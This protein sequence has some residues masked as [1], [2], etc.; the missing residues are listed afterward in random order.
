M[1]IC[2]KLLI[3]CSLI[4]FSNYAVS[5][6][7]LWGLTSTGGAN[8]EGT[9][10]YY[11]L[12]SNSWVTEHNFSSAGGANP[13]GSLALF[14]GKLYGMTTKGGANNKGVIFEY[15]PQTKV[16]TKKVDFTGDNGSTPSGSLTLLNNKF[17]GMTYEGGSKGYG[18][19]FEWDPVTNVIAKKINWDARY[20]Y[21]AGPRGSLLLDN[22]FLYGMTSS[23]AGYDDAFWRGV[24]FKWN[25]ATGTVNSAYL[26]GSGGRSPEGSLTRFGSRFYGLTKLGGDYDG[27]SLIEWGASSP[28]T[29]KVSFNQGFPT[30]SLIA[31]N[32]KLYGL[33]AGSGSSFGY[34]FSWDPSSNSLQ[35]L[36]N[37]DGNN[38]SRP[39]G[40]LSYSNGKLYGLTYEGGA[41]NLGTLFEFDLTTKVLQKKVDFSN[42]TG[43]NPY[44]TQLLEVGPAPEPISQTINFEALSSKTFGDAE[45]SLTAIASSGLEVAYTSS[46]PTVATISGEKVTMLKAGTVV[47]TASQPGNS[48]YRAATSVQQV[49]TISKFTPSL[50]WNNPADIIYGTP[51]TL[52]QLSC[53]ASSSGTLVYTPPLGTVLNVGNNQPLSVTF[54]PSN[55]ASVNSVSL[56]VFINVLNPPPNDESLVQ[57]KLWGVTSTGGINDG[58]TIGYFGVTSGTWTTVYNFE[59]TTG[60][61]PKGSLSLFNGKLYGM[62]SAGGSNNKGVIFEYDPITKTYTKKIDFIGTNGGN[63]TGSL[64]LLNNKFYGMTYSGGSSPYGTLFEWNPSTNEYMVKVNFNGS[65]GAW[66]YGSLLVDNGLLY[67]LTSGGVD[68]DQAFWYGIAFSFDPNSNVLKKINPFNIDNG[69]GVGIAK[70]PTCSLVKFG[71]KFYGVSKFGGSLDFGTIFEWNGTSEISK[72]TP[73]ISFSSSNPYPSGSLALAGDRLYGTTEGPNGSIFEYDPTN[74]TINSGGSFDGVNGKTPTGTFTFSNGKLYG[75]TSSGGTSNLGTLVEYNPTTKI[76]TKKVDFNYSTGGNPVYT[77]LLEIAAA[78]INQIIQFEPIANKIFGTGPFTLSASASSGLN[79][80]FSSSDPTIASISGNTVTI[81]KAGI[82]TITASQSGNSSYNAAANVSQVL[83]IEKNTPTISWENP[84]DINVGTPLSAAQLNATTTVAGSFAYS[85]AIG[86]VLPAGNN[87]PLSVTFTPTNS[88]NYNTVVKQAFVNV[89]NFNPPSDSQIYGFTNSGGASNNGTIFKISPNGD[90]EQVLFNFNISTGSPV[91]KPILASNGKYYGLTR[92]GGASDFGILFEYD[93]TSGIFKKIADMNSV[94]GKNPNGTLIQSSLNGKIYGTCQ[95]GGISGLGMGI[96][97]EFDPATSQV[98]KKISFNATSYYAARNPSGSLLETSTGKIIGVGR[99][100]LFEYDIVGATYKTLLTMGNDLID[101]GAPGPPKDPNPSIILGSDGFIYGSTTTGGAGETSELQHGTLFKIALNGT[102]NFFFS[103]T[104]SVLSGKPN[105]GVT[106]FNGKL[107]GTTGGGGTDNC[108]ELFEFDLS[109]NTMTK[110]AD[111][112]SA[113]TGANPSS[114]LT[115]VDGKL[116][117]MTK[118]GGANGNGTIFEFDPTSGTL[119][120]TFDFNGSNGQP[121]DNNHLFYQPSSKTSQSI[122]FAAIEEKNYGDAPFMLSA[123]A[124]SGLSVSFSSSDPSV[125]LISGNEVTILKA[126]TTT[127]TATQNGNDIYSPSPIV[128]QTLIVNKLIPVITWANPSDIVYGIV[129]N[130]VQ[131]NAVSTVSGTFVYSPSSG[132]QL[133]AGVNQTLSVTF[134]PTD[135]VNYTNVTKQVALNVTKAVPAITWANP[136]DIIYGTTLSVAQLNASSLISGSFVYS[137]SSGTKP[138]AGANQTLSVTFTPTDA[139]NY[140]NVTKQVALNV[141]KAIP[142]ITWANPSDIVYGTTLSVAQL[143]ATSS[144]SG[145]FV[146]SPSSGTKPN[147]GTNQ[148]LSVTFTPTDAVNYTNVTKQVALN[149]TKALPAITWSNPSAIVYGTTLSVAQLNASSSIPGT[150]VYSPSSGTKPNAGA[151]QALSVTFTPTDAVNYTNVTKQ[152]ALNVTKAVPAITWLNPSAIVYG[153]TLSGAQLNASSSIAGTFVYSPS[154]GTKLNAG[155]DQTLEVT[156][157]P[158]DANYHSVT[159]AVTITINKASQQI[160]FAALLDK[161]F[162]ESSFLLDGTASSLLPI[163]Y[164]TNSDKISI[165][166]SQVTL[167]RAGRASITA[168]Q[169]GD[170]NF[171]GAATVSQSFCIKPV[172]PSITLSNLNTSPPLLTSNAS[173]G[174]QWYLDDKPLAGA[175]SQSLIPEKSGVYKTQVTIEDCKSEYSENQIFVITGDLKLNEPI[176]IFPNPVTDWVTVKTGNGIQ[177]IIIYDLTGKEIELRK[178]ANSQE[179]FDVSNYAPGMYLIKIKSENQTSISRFVKR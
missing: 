168:S 67:G 158:T 175:N 80:S 165:T 113:T 74:K 117:G 78:P 141:T 54:S 153:T 89:I 37:F 97:F 70:R 22:G 19:T 76:I 111:F 166:N 73:V 55:P 39:F 57:T 159:K 123:G 107:Y 7:R 108:G 36:A 138:N 178:V 46:D 122:T 82:V 114:S 84:S 44:Y 131:L 128:S 112:V 71:S 77:Q 101:T 75:L 147:A 151:N 132:T 26:S 102:V 87:Q 133:T 52:K 96:L 8:G 119:V 92:N 66:P 43:G 136:S 47:I 143:N 170:D 65:N 90:N 130:N 162:G 157:T 41:S 173:D 109:T 69:P 148:T 79:V 164:S 94:G 91:G 10:G 25:P 9:I 127:I 81:I 124:S 120:K 169:V 63:P 5:Q 139:V 121:S 126:G 24:A 129:L 146:Y 27:G 68:Y 53:T 32:S 174:N 118:L 160:T 171:N 135:A 150:F 88:T 62:T 30:G 72:I 99:N 110:R 86:S 167:L 4:L 20:G 42:S 31:F 61:T 56:Q 23:G 64:T 50:E 144:I 85:P 48:F 156:F 140:T 6:T 14:A 155:L 93:P 21:G 29:I 100:S 60:L 33:A 104:G 137:P 145:S 2:S 177:Q 12:S 51:L 58:G 161:T 149:V 34:I 45:F 125:A 142:A 18:V 83:T 3:C 35:I 28:V 105:A 98:T 176:T 59:S 106:E 134:T 13:K 179:Q 103:F 49:L 15:D 172:K 154:S 17:Y 163:S 116:F 16:Y 11:E 38:G 115:I 40:S 95:Y 1:K 152:V